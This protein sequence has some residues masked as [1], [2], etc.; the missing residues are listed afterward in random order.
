[1][2]LL[3]NLPVLIKSYKYITIPSS[4]VFVI[5]SFIIFNGWDQIDQSENYNSDQDENDSAFVFFSFKN[6]INFL[7]GFSWTGI[8]FDDIIESEVSLLAVSLIVGFAFVLLFSFIGQQ[9]RLSTKNNKF[10]IEHA[11]NKTAEVYLSIPENKKGMGKIIVFVNGVSHQ[12][13]AMTENG[14]IETGTTVK[15][16]KIADKTLIVKQIHYK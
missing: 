5:Q 11:I 16:E 13:D 3:S 6:L 15:V 9:I 1:M 10:Q 8:L 7:F 14:T 4:I 12:L 2:F